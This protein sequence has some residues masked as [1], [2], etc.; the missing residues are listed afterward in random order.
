MILL[1]VTSIAQ[2]TDEVNI[3]AEQ[4]PY[5]MGCPDLENGTAEKRKCSN[6]N[7]IDFI[8]SNV[9]YPQFARDQ[10]IEGTVFVKFVVNHYG[11]VESSEVLRDIGGDCGKEGLR[12]VELMPEWEPALNEGKPVSVSLS[13]PVTFSLQNAN[14]LVANK[15]QI[16]WGTLRGNKT[17]KEEL[18]NYL[19][20]K[21]HVRDEM[22]EEVD[23][24]T[25]TFI[26]Q[27]KRVFLEEN[28]TGRINK[29]MEKLIKRVKKGGTFVIVAS[30]QRE[31]EIYEIE[32]EF[33]VF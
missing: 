3:I 27:R 33:E 32:R 9:Q 22:G 19:T 4:M 23:I 5:F 16:Q 1:T 8:N 6:K 14:A 12:L 18:K 28:S 7:L 13:L 26:F 15:Y 17:S 21:L 24:S 29:K 2:P 11:I 30:I 10:G 20:K 31:G 25:L